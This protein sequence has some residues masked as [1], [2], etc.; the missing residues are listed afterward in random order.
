MFDEKQIEIE[1]VMTDGCS[2]EAGVY[3]LGPVFLLS[4][5]EPVK[6]L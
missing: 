2:V 3:F 6:P 1:M 5:S 4:P